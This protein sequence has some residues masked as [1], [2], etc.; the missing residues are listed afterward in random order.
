MARRSDDDYNT[1]P[2]R[3]SHVD[4]INSDHINTF[5]DVN[6]QRTP[7]GL[8]RIPAMGGTGELKQIG[9]GLH[10]PNDRIARSTFQ[11]EGMQESDEWRLGSRNGTDDESNTQHFISESP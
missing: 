3:G 11:N 1:L 4:I 8:Q 7:G 6:V 2:N 5:D 10:G 9:H